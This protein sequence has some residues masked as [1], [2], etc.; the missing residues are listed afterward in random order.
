ML[1]NGINTIVVLA[2][3]NNK[4]AGYKIPGSLL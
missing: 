1:I 4:K 3:L 2:N